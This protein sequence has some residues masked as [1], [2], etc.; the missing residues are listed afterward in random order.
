MPDLGGSYADGDR[1]AYAG[2]LAGG[3]VVLAAFVIGA[4][5]WFRYHP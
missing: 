2:W 3:L 1:K 5:F 4:A